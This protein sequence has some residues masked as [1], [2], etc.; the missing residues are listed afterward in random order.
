MVEGNLEAAEAKKYV[1]LLNQEFIFS[2]NLHQ[3]N[4][5]NHQGAVKRIVTLVILKIIAFTLVHNML[6]LTVNGHDIKQ[7][8]KNVFPFNIRRSKKVF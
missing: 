1:A 2:F 3:I 6:L 5:K 4:N 7:L 8:E